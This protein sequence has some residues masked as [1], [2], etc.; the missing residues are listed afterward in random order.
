MQ[1]TCKLHYILNLQC[2]LTQSNSWNS[3]TFYAPV[4]SHA[5]KHQPVGKFHALLPMLKVKSTH[6]NKNLLN[7]ICLSS[8]ELDHFLTFKKQ[9]VGRLY[10]LSFHYYHKGAVSLFRWNEL[11]TK[12]CK[13]KKK[14]EKKLSQN[15]KIHQMMLTHRLYNM[16]V[17][18][19]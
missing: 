13:K 16:K 9:E 19:S 18:D 10:I 3:R 12:V 7:G 14:W 17:K 5:N 4:Q 11:W 8:I 1:K 15:Q 2:Y 6:D